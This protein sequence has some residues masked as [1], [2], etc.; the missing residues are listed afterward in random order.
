MT[1]HNPSHTVLGP[2][3]AEVAG[4]PVGFCAECNEVPTDDI[5]LDFMAD[6]IKEA[7]ISL[8]ASYLEWPEARAWVPT[9]VSALRTGGFRVRPID[10]ST[11]G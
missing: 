11:D 2:K 7:S 4:L 10:G 3:G 6:G 1:E 9:V 5:Y 8:G